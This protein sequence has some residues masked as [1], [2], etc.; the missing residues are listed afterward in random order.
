MIGLCLPAV[1]LLCLTACG[2]SGEPTTSRMPST[3][4][5]TTTPSTTTPVSSKPVKVA[6][7]QV[8][9]PPAPDNPR[10]D[11][12][13]TA[14][15]G[16]QVEL[17]HQTVEGEGSWV[18]LCNGPDGTLFASDQYGTL[19]QITPPPVGDYDAAATI[20]KH[21][22]KM[23]GA[24]GMVWVN[25]TL[26]IMATGRGVEI[27]TDADQDGIYDGSNLILPVKG[28]GEH[29]TH[30]LIPDPKGGG[31]YMV[32]G[33]MTPLPPL[34]DSREPQ[35][36]EEDQLLKREPDANGHA[37]NVMAPG[38]WIGRMDFDGSNFTLHCAGFRNSYDIAF[39][40]N[41][42]LFT[43]DSDM[44]WDQGMPWYRPTRVN[45][46]VSGAEF[47]WRN[48][49]GKW[50]SYYPDSLPAVVDIGPGSPTGVL[51][52]YDAKFPTKY[53][54][55]FYI[56]DWT[57]G[58]MYAVHL[59]PDGASY[60]ATFEPFIS[61]KPLPLT[62]A[63]IGADGAMYV[64]TGGRRLESK[65]YRVVYYGKKDQTEPTIPPLNDL[66][67][68]RKKIEQ[69]HSKDAPAEAIDVAWPHLAHSDRFIRYAARIA[70]E[71]QPVD[72]WLEKAQAE[73]DPAAR[74]TLA[75]ALA[76]TAPDKTLAYVASIDPEK[77]DAERKLAYLRALQVAFAREAQKTDSLMVKVQPVIDALAGSDDTRIATEAI[78]LKVYLENPDAVAVVLKKIEEADP[79]QPPA[80]AHLAAMNDRYGKV[81][82]DMVKYPPPT[83]QLLYVFML[84]DVKDGWTI[85]QRKFYFD[86]LNRAALAEGGNS[87]AKYLDKI[88]AQAVATLTPEELAELGD[89]VNKPDIKNRELPTA[90]AP[91]GQLRNL[92]VEQANA[93][94][95]GKLTGRNFDRGAGLFVSQ[96]ANCHRMG[97]FGSAV[98]PDLTSLPNKYTAADMVKATINPNADVSDQYKMQLIQLKEGAPVM[99]M[100]MSAD[101]NKL[102][103]K[104]NPQL[105]DTVEVARSNVAAITPLPTSPMP[106]GLMNQMTDDEVRDL[107]A[108]LVSGG[109]KSK[110]DFK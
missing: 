107:I 3:T 42:E 24:Q 28:G 73:K 4:P 88:R 76:R 32:S 23:N 84:R 87:Y 33:N 75:L 108:Y 50:P 70:L 105:E 52:G 14:P 35:N 51:F 39:D 67:K 62:D 17:I 63:V 102:V 55:A 48:G 37:S 100:L 10:A 66:A 12:T 81:I 92:T 31:I 103:L 36:W 16:F 82:A 97:S 54:S 21:E 30:A 20:V 59:E 25:D 65:L 43:W 79:P 44:E 6:Q 83:E 109:D 89:L 34:V 41:G 5:S 8:V 60:S 91:S 68:L 11:D 19:F 95:D 74:A 56:L 26:Y 101:D 104:P 99:G 106:A 27:V 29:G 7:P 18:A 38:G 64:T 78:R 9:E 94:I 22:V 71:H 77:L 13:V 86:W 45:H 80:W 15:A 93:I 98:G 40:Q 72:R 47:G 58:V 110:G 1:A 46:A 61:G 90:V 69:Y 53:Q 57:Y 85:E 2:D 96:C 49:S